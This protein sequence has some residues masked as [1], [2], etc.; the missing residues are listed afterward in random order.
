MSRRP[1]ACIVRHSYYPA[2]LNVKREAE[3][4]L[5]AGFDV[6][7]ICLRDRGEASREVVDGVNVRRLP[8][9]HRREGVGRYLFEYGSIFLL[10]A[11]TLTALH[12]LRRFDAVQVNTMPDW[13]VFSALVPRLTGA[14]VVLHMHEPM[15]ELWRTSFA[16]RAFSGPIE[17]AI[18]AAERWSLR[19]AHRALTVTET[20]KAR[21]VERG[22]DPDK[23]TVVLNVPDDR[24]FDRDR[25]KH[26]APAVREEGLF[27][28]VSHGALEERYGITTIL[29]AVRL[30]RKEVPGLRLTL[31]GKGRM[32]PEVRRWIETEGLEPHVH[33]PGY[34]DFETM[35]A[36]IL[37]ADAGVV[38]QLENSYSRLIHTNK[39]FEYVALGVPVIAARLEA[40]RT[41]FGDESFA[42]FRP[43]DAG[44]L[45]RA[46]VQAAFDPARL[47]SLA[48]AAGAVYR[49][50]RWSR[51]KKR[52]LGAFPRE[53]SA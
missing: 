32:E 6:Q 21:F 14:R 37:E 39:M 20:L 17:K 34:V 22:A 18:L 1:R 11:A 5:E 26:L 2:E 12:M 27:R 25:W 45:A 41:T 43:G 47:A 48:R 8:V 51:E 38:A 53:G 16:G 36:R 35:I 30:A 23:I 9:R 10:A 3:A 52:Y 29:D 49:E 13:L 7:V 4:L 33:F 46:I 50:H 28:L 42:Y 31:M 40:V 19:F 24:L 44:D 15:P